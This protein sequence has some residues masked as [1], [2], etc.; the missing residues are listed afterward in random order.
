M[1]SS[2]PKRE[3]SPCQQGVDSQAAKVTRHSIP[4]LPEVYIF[5]HIHC[6]MT[7]R[8]AARAAC[9]SRAFLRSWRG[10][11]NLIF[12]EDMIGLKTSACRVNFCREIDTILR[13]HS[14]IGVKIFKLVCRRMCEVDDTSRYLD[15][16]L[17]VAVKPGIEEPTLMV[18]HTKTEYNFPCSLLSDGIRNSIRYLKLRCCGLHPAPELGPLR[19]VTSLCLRIVS[20]NGDE[21][22]CLLSNSLALEQLE[23]IFCSDII[24][25]KISC[26]LQQLTSLRVCLC[27]NLTAIESKAPN[28]SSLGTVSKRGNTNF[29]LGE[30]LQ[31]KKMD[32]DCPNAV[33]YALTELP[34]IMPN[35]ETLVI[36][37]PTEV[38]NTPMLPTKFLYL[39]HLTVHL[40]STSGMAPFLPPYDYFSLVSFLDASPSLETLMLNATPCRMKHENS[41]L[42]DASHLRHMPEHRHGCL[43]SFKISQFSSEKSLVELTCYI[44]KNAVSLECLTLNTNH[45]HRKCHLEIYGTCTLTTADRGLLAIRTYIED[46]VPGSVKLTVLEPC[47]RCHGR[48]HC[49]LCNV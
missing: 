49:K 13:N 35:L 47:S 16:W 25:L 48:G 21:L 33:H 34:S 36:G 46:K 44:L 39:K 8:E 43:K 5:G 19:S 24:R 37:S 15:S 22:E 45:G 40:I 14:G 2:V 10:R 7:M 27:C 29:S 3:G 6:L 12:N 28:L 42:A 1:D 30:T 23:L 31:M 9:V 20:I 18:C 17:Q 26:A 4:E 32:V 41:T 38:P 11:P